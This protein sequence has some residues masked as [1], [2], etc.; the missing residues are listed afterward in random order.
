LDIEH[1][2]LIK[3]FAYRTPDKNTRATGAK[4]RSSVIVTFVC[5]SNVFN[6]IASAVLFIL[7]TVD[8]TIKIIPKRCAVPLYFCNETAQRSYAKLI[9]V[10]ILP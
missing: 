4:L 3:L 5:E 10:M 2:G 6:F 9:I 8:L 7:H 1:V